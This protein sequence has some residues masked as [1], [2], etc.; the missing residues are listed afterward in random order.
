MRTPPLV[1]HAHWGLARQ[2]ADPEHDKEDITRRMRTR[3]E[4][5]SVQCLPVAE[6]N[7]ARVDLTVQIPVGKARH[8]HRPT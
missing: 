7:M 6:W 3:S 5:F 1:E 2:R 4:Q 8:P